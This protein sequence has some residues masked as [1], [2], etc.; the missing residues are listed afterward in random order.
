MFLED[1]LLNAMSGTCFV[2]YVMFDHS[3]ALLEDAKF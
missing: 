2:C 3:Y 1:L